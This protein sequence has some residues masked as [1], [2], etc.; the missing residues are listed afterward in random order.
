MWKPIL[1][2]EGWYEISDRGEVRSVDRRVTGADGKT[3]FFHSHPIKRHL[4]RDGYARARLCRPGESVTAQVHVLVCEAFHGP[5]P[6]R[7]AE[8]CHANDIRDDNRPENLSW[9]TR[10][11][12]CAEMAERN[13]VEG[14][15]HHRAKVTA[16]QA[17]ML[18]ELPHYRGIHSDLAARFGVSRGTISG[19]R[20]GYNWGWL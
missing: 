12:N 18:R 9:G 4:D 6:G 13:G 19:I 14:E 1:G 10:Q 15:K 17:F 8:V 16:F 3:Y 5:R 7:D 2:W 20:G 11:S